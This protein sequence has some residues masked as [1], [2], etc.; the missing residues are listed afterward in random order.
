[1]LT[2]FLEAGF[3][4]GNDIFNSYPSIDAFCIQLKDVA[5][6]THRKLKVVE[7]IAAHAVR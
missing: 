1:M 2:V 5:D 4:F 6:R 3:S 7:K